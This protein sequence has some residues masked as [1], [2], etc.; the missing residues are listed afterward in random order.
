MARR[1]N[2][3]RIL[4]LM[5]QDLVPPDD[6]CDVSAKEFELYK[7]EHDVVMTL[8]GLGHEVSK[9]GLY[10][11][12]QP[13]REAI[14]EWQPHIVFNL[15]EEFGGMTIYD[16]NMVSYLELMG[17]PY[18]G[19]S[20]RGL[21]LARDKALAKKIL[22]FH[23]IR[24]PRFA[25]FPIGRRARLPRHL[26]FPVIVKSQL[27]EAS[28]GIAQASV[29][30]TEAAL[31]ERVAFVHSNVGTAAICEQY[32][33]GREINIAILGNQRLEVLPP[34]ELRFTKLPKNA[35]RIATHKVKWDLDYQKQN[36]I[37]IGQATDLPAA[38]LSEM[39]AMC[40]RAYRALD[41][42]GY[43]RMDL[44]LAPDGRPFLIEANPNCDISRDEEFAGAAIAAGYSYGQLLQR[45]V[46][47]GLKRKALIRRPGTS[48]V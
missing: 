38:T 32:V 11:E 33:D 8:R 18:T 10:D 28:L 26:S 37:E 24:S 22:R 44:R 20:P 21:L 45:I 5:H 2:K 34:W 47:L 16:H 4:A 19:N 43:A 17:M 46:N 39:N 23:R 42:T 6:L 9:L 27:E 14:T 31:A 1:V 3:R 35:W 30:S 29:V 13:L 12:L 41:L 7:A 48:A 40:K 36:G 15:L 25:L